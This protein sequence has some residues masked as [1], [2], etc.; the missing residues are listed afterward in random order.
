[1][2]VKI[3]TLNKLLGSSTGWSPCSTLPRR[4][5]REGREMQVILPRRL[6]FVVAPSGGG[7]L[8]TMHCAQKKNYVCITLCGNL[9]SW[10]LG[11]FFFLFYLNRFLFPPRLLLPYSVRRVW[12]IRG[13]RQ[14]YRGRNRIH[15]DM[16]GKVMSGVRELMSALNCGGR[17]G[18]KV[19]WMWV[20]MYINT[21]LYN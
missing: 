2:V 4:D 17:K 18:R 15:V 13:A 5:F 8:R 20:L 16:R 1:M 21:Y 12:L 7:F 19:W 6:R 9:S 14:Q 10:C 3:P 11:F